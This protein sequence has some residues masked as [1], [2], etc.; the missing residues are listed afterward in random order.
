MARA[1]GRATPARDKRDQR[2][3]RPVARATGR[4]TPARDKRGQRGSE[5][6]AERDQR[7]KLPDELPDARQ[8]LSTRE[9]TGGATEAVGV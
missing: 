9:T 8:K 2:G 5:I 6:S 1:T 7:R 3:A 4:A